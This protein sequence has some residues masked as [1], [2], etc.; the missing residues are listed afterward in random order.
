MGNGRDDVRYTLSTF[1]GLLL[2]VC[3]DTSAQ[4]SVTPPGLIAWWNGDSGATDVNQGLVA[5]L[6]GSQVV[7]G[8]IGSTYRF[9]G[10][11]DQIVVGNPTE[12]QF[13]QSEF[14]VELWV[15]FAEFGAPGG[16]TAPCA[17]GGGC[18]MSLV[19]KMTPSSIV[20][21]ANLD[22][23]RILKQSDNH[24]WFC[25]GGQGV[26]NNGCAPGAPTTLRSQGPVQLDE[27]IHVAATRGSTS[28]SLYLNGAI[29]ET[30]P[31]PTHF[32][33][34]TAQL[35]F[36][37][38]PLLPLDPAFGSKFSGDMDEISFYGRELSS[39]EIAAIHDAGPSGK[40]LPCSS[41]SSMALGSSCPAAGGPQLSALAPSLGSSW[42]MN[43]T[44]APVLAPAFVLVSQPGVVNGFTAKGCPFHLDPSTLAPPIARESDS[45][46]DLELSFTLPPDP[47]FC[48][49]ELWIQVF[50]LPPP[51]QSVQST[52][53]L[54]LVLGA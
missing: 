49:I 13:S 18:D 35:R 45:S 15:R 25:F 26:S 23:W 16:T 24:I 21:P 22:G 32:D 31:L 53:A 51:P 12:L 30:K 37:F 40:C 42:T 38:F 2:G 52:N 39:L 10:V 46:G 7:P 36:G 28:I 9:D 33:S 6:D 34:D 48:G 4:C 17:P 3:G 11:D 50:H 41:A 5:V 1:F 8:L 44:G 54:A 27:W 47:A 29:E 43:V 14:T 20:S 19:S